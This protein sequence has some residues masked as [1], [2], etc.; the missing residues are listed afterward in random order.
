[1][2]TQLDIWKTKWKNFKGKLPD[3]LQSLM[4]ET[5]KVIFPSIYEVIQ[6]LATIP[7]T[8][9]SCE[10]SIS[11]LRRVETMDEKYHVRGTI[12]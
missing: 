12:K 7:V 5:D 10:R 1:M 3:N 4:K 8:T 6:I 9:C 11:G 2:C